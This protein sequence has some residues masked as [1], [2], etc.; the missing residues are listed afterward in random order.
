MRTC[1][2]RLLMH[3][4]KKEVDSPMHIC[5]LHDAFHHVRRAVK[6]DSIKG[7]GTMGSDTASLVRRVAYIVV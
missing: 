6:G 4:F 2:P 7:G 1:R 5:T 3:W